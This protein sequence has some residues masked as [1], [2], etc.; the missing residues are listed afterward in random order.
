MRA[1]SR[2]LDTQRAACTSSDV[3][4]SALSSWWWRSSWRLRARL[5][6]SWVVK[7]SPSACGSGRSACVWRCMSHACEP[8][9]LSPG[10][11]LKRC[12]SACC[13]QMQCVRAKLG[14]LR[15]YGLHW[16]VQRLLLA[17][18]CHG[19]LLRTLVQTAR[20]AGCCRGS[21]A[22]R[23]QGSCGGWAPPVTGHA[24]DSHW[25]RASAVRGLGLEVLL[26]SRI[27]LDRLTAVCHVNIQ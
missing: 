15:Q 6:R 1:R 2:S 26:L 16:E 7:R 12:C 9:Q 8:D 5:E 13:K 4:T 10:A 20:N 18:M 11:V 21:T 17:R 22:V 14:Q 25:T 19:Y 27:H 24:S 3:C 23:S